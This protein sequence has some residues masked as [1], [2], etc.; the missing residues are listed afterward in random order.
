MIKLKIEVA[1][2]PATLA[3][4]LMH[5][6]KLAEDQ[7]MLFK[8]PMVLEASFWGKDTYIPLDVAFVS[9]DGRINGIKSITPLSTRTVRSDRACSMAIEANAGFFEKNKIDIGT[10][11]EIVRD[12]AG[13]E[14]ELIFKSE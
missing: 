13:K 6:E 1:D 14:M 10:K 8:F 9:P 11:V 2:S 4:G 12:H 7:G 5:R 3:R